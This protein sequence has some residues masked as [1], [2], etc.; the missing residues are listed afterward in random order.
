MFKKSAVIFLTIIWF[1]E[2]HS[3]SARVRH[4]FTGQNF[5]IKNFIFPSFSKYSLHWNKQIFLQISF[6]KFYV[7]SLQNF[8]VAPKFPATLKKDWCFGKF[9]SNVS[10]WAKIYNFFS[11]GISIENGKNLRKAK[12][13]VLI[14]NFFLPVLRL[15][16]A[17]LKR[18][19]I[20]HAK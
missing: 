10:T 4:N 11:R 7:Q 3:F 15:L 13:F 20:Q 19:T 2:I 5:L 14:L 18:K 12:I 16:A 6:F 9:W 1:F 8:N 17:L